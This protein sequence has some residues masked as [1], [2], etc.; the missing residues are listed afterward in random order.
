MKPI[1]KDKIAVYKYKDGYSADRGE[2]IDDEFLTVYGDIVTPLALFD[3]NPIKKST[4]KLG[5][6][7]KYRIHD[8]V[9]CGVI[10]VVKDFKKK[11][12]KYREYYDDLELL[13]SIL[14]HNNII[15]KVGFVKL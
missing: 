4:Y 6:V 15:G 14:L 5:D 8:E 1:K 10:V 11:N 12:K 13:E 7:V 2:E 3:D 9:F